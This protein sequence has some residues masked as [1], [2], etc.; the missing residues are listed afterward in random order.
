M[1]RRLYWVHQKEVSSSFSIRCYGK[2]QLNFLA[3]PIRVNDWK[4][5]SE[6]LI[7]QKKASFWYCDSNALLSFLGLMF[8]IYFQSGIIFYALEKKRSWKQNNTIFNVTY[9]YSFSLYYLLP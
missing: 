6:L 9:C 5:S 3:I 2:T 8:K 4:G 1:Q 7:L